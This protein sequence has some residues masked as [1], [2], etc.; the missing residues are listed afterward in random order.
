MLRTMQQEHAWI[1]ASAAAAATF[2]RRHWQRDARLERSAR[3]GVLA[4]IEPAMLLALACRDDVESRLVR[5]AGRRWQ[6]EH[7]PFPRRVLERLPARGWSLLVQGA[8]RHLPAARALMDRFA[9]IP[10]TRHDD[11]MLSLAPAG[12]GGGAHVVSYDVFLVLARGRRRWRIGR[13]RDL[14]LVPGA[15]LRILQ[16]FQPSR[17][18]V[19]ETGDVL[20]LPP[21]YAHEGV[22]LDECITCSV[23]LRAPTRQEI[24]ASFL[25]WLPDTVTF[26]GRCAGGE[27]TAAAHPAEISAAMVREVQGILASIRWPRAAVERFVGEHWSEP[28]AQVWFRAP[29]PLLPFARFVRH[30]RSH[31]VRLALGTRKLFR[32]ELIFDNGDSVQARGPARHAL[33]DLAD[34]RPATPWRRPAVAAARHLSDWSRAGYVALA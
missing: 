13:Q 16:K 2:M 7:G 27:R 17:E 5:R 12:G 19:V 26:S 9:F 1:G 34:R 15:P 28:A 11:V 8:D 4:S 25:A 24:A 32:R 29:Q 22:A 18:V 10:Y 33:V 21:R 3:R 30:A 6:V 31:G 23:G 20:Y 14:T